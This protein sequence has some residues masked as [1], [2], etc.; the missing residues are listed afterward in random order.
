MAQSILV[1]SHDADL[2]S[3]LGEALE[4]AGAPDCALDHA[5]SRALATRVWN[6]NREAF[7]AVVVDLA[8]RTEAL[9]IIASLRAQ[10]STTPIF[11]AALNDAVSSNV[12]A[13][14][15]AGA[16]GVFQ[17]I[18]EFPRLLSDHHTQRKIDSK[19]ARLV[20]F[21]PAQDG[22]GAS[23]AALHTANYLATRHRARTLLAELDYH[24]D[25]VSYR[26]RL[27]EVKSLSDLGPEDTWRTAVA[28]WK[29]L[30]VL[31]APASGRTLRTRSLPELGQTMAECCQEY[32]YVVADLPC[33]TAVAT[34][35]LLS[36]AD[37]IYVVA[38]AEVTSL[39][40]ARRRVLNLVTAGA[41]TEAIRLV[42][43][44][45]RTGAVDS[46]LASQVT[47]FSPHRR[48][49]NDFSAASIAETEAGVV[50]SDSDLGKAYAELAADLAGKP[51][52][53]AAPAS[54]RSWS[55]LLGWR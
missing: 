42:I 36:S 7:S 15:R 32:D 44:R 2:V 24:S 4:A 50:P 19:K 10:G 46:D 21:A 52:A 13:A 8:Q 16:K 31:P 11:A 48:L 5:P 51:A 41:E 28:T 6:A 47:G 35:M 40:L 30:D 27:P 37:R 53:V 39:Y 49:P 55:K 54:P 25:S 26:L 33:N 23:T 22:A 9:T 18:E 34:S 45:D 14:T 1:A 38:T 17:R 3:R 20:L 29:G 12:V 43:N